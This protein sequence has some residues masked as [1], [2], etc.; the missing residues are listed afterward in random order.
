MKNIIESQY[1]TSVDDIQEFFSDDG[2]EYFDCGQGYYQDDAEVIVKIDGK[3]YKVNMTAEIGSERQDRGDRLYFVERVESVKVSEMT[4]L[5]V[6]TQV[7]KELIAVVDAAQAKLD[8][9]QKALV[10]HIET[11][12]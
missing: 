2:D 10:E 9:A 12:V 5:D 6:H 1:L 4:P 8:E 3:Y 11:E 7:K